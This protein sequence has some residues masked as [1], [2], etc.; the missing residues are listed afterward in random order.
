M[1]AGAS[2]PRVGAKSDLERQ[3]RSLERHVSG[4]ERAARARF[5]SLLKQEI[6]DGERGELDFLTQ[7]FQPA[8]EAAVNDV[9]NL[10]GVVARMP[11]VE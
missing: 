2:G 9:K 7:V 8:V 11:D 10:T 4:I 3:L 1:V 5:D 6:D